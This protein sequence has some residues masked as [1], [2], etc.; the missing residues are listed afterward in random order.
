MN[1][2]ELENMV[3]KEETP[4]VKKEYS[5]NNYNK[6]NSYGKKED[7]IN[8]YEVD[9]IPSK[10]IDTD[11]FEKNG[12]SFAVHTYEI[13]PD[14]EKKMMII[15]NALVEQ[16][17][18]FRHNGNKED[19]IQNKILEID[20]IKVESY[21][22]YAKFNE[23]IA[24]PIISNYYELPFNYAAQLYGQRYNEMKKGARSIYA[25]KVQS[26][27]GKECTNPVDFFLCYSPDGSET[28]PKF[29]KGKKYDYSKLGTLGF[30]LKVTDKSGIAT[31]NFK[32]DASIASLVKLIK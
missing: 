1:F 17:F 4:Y 29:E 9:V 2:D 7:K 6:N 28:T 31:Y 19:E 15:A 14:A 24:K 13:T 20:N 25:S 22:P 3:S 10:E 12:R 26:L 5:N 23:D 27:L 21:L 16:G 8:M 18:V 32:N 30:Y 11:I